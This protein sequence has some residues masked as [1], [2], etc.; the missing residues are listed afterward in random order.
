MSQPSRDAPTLRDAAGHLGR[1]F[2]LIRPYWGPIGRSVVMAIVLGLVGLVPPWVTKLLIDLVYPTG[3]ASLLLVLVLAALSFTLSGAILGGL[4][5]FYTVYVDSRLTSATRLAFWNHLQHLR[6]R[7]FRGHQVGEINSRFQ[8]VALALKTLSDL[9]QT[10]F[11]QGIYLVLVP[12]LLFWLEWRLALLALVGVPLTTGLTALSGRWLRPRWQRTSEALAEIQAYQVETL[13]HIEAYKS[14]GLEPTVYRRA[15]GLIETALEHQLRARGLSELFGAA[16][17]AVKALNLALFTWFGWTL[18]LDGAMTLGDFIAFTSYVNLLYG[19]VAQ[20]IR[21]FGQVQQASVHLGRMFEYLDEPPEQDPNDA[22]RPAAPIERRLRGAY[23]L[24][25]VRFAYSEAAPEAGVFDGLD[26]D[27]SA[28]D[29]TVLVG[30]SG[31]GKTTLLRLLCGLE[32]PSGG[33]LTIDGR[34]VDEIGLRDLRRQ[35]AVVWQDPALLRGTLRENLVLGADETSF[36]EGMD[37]AIERAVDL[38]ALGE[39]VRAL[40]AGLETPVAEWGASLSAGQRQRVAL[41]RAL[42][43]DTPIVLFDEA[44]SHLDVGTERR[45]LDRLLDHLAGRT[46]VFATHRLAVTKRARRVA[47]LEEGRLVGFDA[48]DRLLATCETYREM[49]GSET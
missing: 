40:P 1:L 11:V 6:P 3:D 12:P 15:R 2:L 45:V 31:S 13:S 19:P 7:F 38:C 47:V 18:I 29:L 44:T 4:R 36:P 23:R 8:D 34:T 39:V 28:G 27:L 32:R 26:L 42:L 20:W 49:H 48:H 30:A 10:V 35:V 16:N 37:A 25:D 24:R 5:S 9:F 33:S 22:G 41:A 17:T 43:R 14:M 46:L 21:L